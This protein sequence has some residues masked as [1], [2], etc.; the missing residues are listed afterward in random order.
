MRGCGWCV[1]VAVLRNL[2]VSTPQLSVR[3][4]VVTVDPTLITYWG[5]GAELKSSVR[6]CSD[7]GY[8]FVEIF[9]M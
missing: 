6:T 5:G 4:S 2:G 7:G 1:F 8:N 9:L 3:A